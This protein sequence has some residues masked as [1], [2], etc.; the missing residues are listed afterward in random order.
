MPA[1]PLA[2]KIERAFI[3]CRAG[4]PNTGT[5]KLAE[6]RDRLAFAGTLGELGRLLTAAKIRF[7][8]I[9]TGDGTAKATALA[10]LMTAARMP[11]QAAAN[12]L[13]KSQTSPARHW[14]V[15]DWL[16]GGLER[17]IQGGTPTIFASLCDPATPANAIETKENSDFS[18]AVCV[19][20]CDPAT[21]PAIDPATVCDPVFDVK[22]KLDAFGELMKQALAD[23]DTAGY[24]T[25]KGMMELLSERFPTIKAVRKHLEKHPAVRRKK[26]SPQ[27]LLIHVG[28]LLKS[29]QNAGTA[30]DPLD[31]PAEIVD[32]AVKE[33]ELRK[34][35]EKLH[36]K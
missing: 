8:C 4:M 28:D 9:V 20:V 17:E 35:K 24:I 22:A 34:A 11:P 33:M 1:I 7:D 23:A 16:T 36:K 25:A 6:R 5:S 27:R 13:L 19:P 32:K 31:L 15:M 18:G 29:L 3:A 14:E 12:L 30:A 26:P 21:V 2:T 10:I